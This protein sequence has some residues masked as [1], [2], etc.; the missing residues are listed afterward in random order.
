VGIDRPYRRT[1]RQFVSGKYDGMTPRSYIHHPRFAKSPEHYIRAF[2]LIQKDLHT[3][4]DYV[5]PADKNLECYS[6][7]IHELLLRASI[8][9]EANCKAILEENG[10]KTKA[11]WDTRDY[12]KIEQSHRLSKYEVKLPIWSGNHNVRTPFAE[13]SGAGELSWYSAY[14]ATKHNRQVDFERAT[15]SQML[16]GVSGLLALISSQFGTR[17]F[18]PG[19]ELISAEMGGERFESSIGGYFRVRFPDD[20]A[21]ADRYDFNWEKLSSSDPDPFQNFPYP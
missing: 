16:D 8:E 4:F 18:G 17:D 10:Y 1:C 20:W 3:L 15:F 9:V 14:N 5:E 11:R 6:Y 12:R 13:W 21:M 19:P 7:R 2:L